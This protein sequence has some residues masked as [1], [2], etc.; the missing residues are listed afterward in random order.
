MFSL[1]MLINC[2]ISVGT[3]YLCLLMLATPHLCKTEAVMVQWQYSHVQIVHG[4][5]FVA[6]IKVKNLPGVGC[7]APA[8][9]YHPC[10]HFL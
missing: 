7:T 8:Q 4:F 6:Q 2:C 5:E 1:V 3:M 10:Y 9:S